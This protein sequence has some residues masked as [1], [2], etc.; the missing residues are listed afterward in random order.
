MR[1]PMPVFHLL[2]SRSRL[3]SM[4]E[5]QAVVAIPEGKTIL[6]AGSVIAAQLLE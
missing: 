3:Q 2:R 1:S 5:A 4:A 6:P